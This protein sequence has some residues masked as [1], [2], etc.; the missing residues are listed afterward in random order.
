MD[1]TN[2]MSRIVGVVPGAWGN[3]A[4][5][6]TLAALQSVCGDMADCDLLVPGDAGIEQVR[7]LAGHAGIKRVHCI[8]GDGAA[9][10]AEPDVAARLV[11]EALSQTGGS[12]PATLILTPPG[13]DGEEL[14]ARVAFHM[15]G[16]ALGRCENVRVE[17]HGVVAT[18]SAWGGRKQLVLNVSGG[19]SVASMRAGKPVL[20]SSRSEAEQFA[21]DVNVELPPEPS[22]DQEPTGESLPPVESARFVVSGGR[23]LNEEGFAQL[24][25][26]ARKA[27]GTLGGSLPAVDAGLVPV[28]RQ[29]G[30]SGKFVTPEL[31]FAVGISGTPQHMAGVSPDTRIVAIN[32]DPEAPIFSMAE[33]GVVG[34]WQQLLPEILKAL[35]D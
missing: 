13:P 12:E 27:K 14:A 2:Q 4:V 16:N 30:I 34:E 31:Y 24:E 29:V 22:L 11:S 28:V 15:N 3:E 17:D 8:T 9:D 18:R 35:D 1:Q 23:G 32:K 5:E 19:L 6:T 7:E 20:D 10:R 26:I 33:A 25:Q 21:I